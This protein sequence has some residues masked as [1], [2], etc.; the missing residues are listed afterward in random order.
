MEAKCGPMVR[1]LRKELAYCQ[2]GYMQV[3]ESIPYLT[4][5]REDEA[6][7]DTPCLGLR[8]PFGTAPRWLWDSNED[9]RLATLNYGA[10]YRVVGGLFGDQPLVGGFGPTRSVLN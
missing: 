8:G 1:W 4:A 6:L 9:R 3:R 10:L 7:L 2:L 5:L